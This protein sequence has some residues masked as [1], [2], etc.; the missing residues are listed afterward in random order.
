M[1]IGNSYGQKN[2]N[3]ILFPRDKF[4]HTHH[5]HAYPRDR[6]H[7]SLASRVRKNHAITVYFGHRLETQLPSIAL[8]SHSTN[9]LLRPNKA[10]WE[11]LGFL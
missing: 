6:L 9:H 3:Q 5:G 10:I 4:D 1:N 8:S 7:I 11:S 2:S